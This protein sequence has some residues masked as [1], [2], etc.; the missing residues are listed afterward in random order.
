MDAPALS[1]DE[2]HRALRHV[3]TFAGVYPSDK[4][5]LLLNKTLPFSVVFNYDDSSKGGSHWVSACVKPSSVDWFDSFGVSP[6]WEDPILNDNTHFREFLKAWGLPVTWNTFD[7]QR[8][9]SKNCGRWATV[10][11]AEG[12]KMPKK[13]LK[14][15]PIDRENW[16][17]KRFDELAN[18]Q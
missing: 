10:Y 7:F 14:M 9:D 1:G 15:S 4:A 11:V 2:I 8:L 18:A 17:V 5:S 6:D 16:V 3:P 12:C 13:L